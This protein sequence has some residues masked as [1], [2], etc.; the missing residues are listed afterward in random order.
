MANKK[1]HFLLLYELS[2]H[3]H[4]TR[5]NIN[6][7]WLQS[8]QQFTFR[9]SVI[10][11]EH[12]NHSP[13]HMCGLNFCSAL[14]FPKLSFIG[15]PLRFLLIPIQY[16]PDVSEGLIS[17]N[18]VTSIR[19]SDDRSS[20]QVTPSLPRGVVLSFFILKNIHLIVVKIPSYTSTLCST[21]YS[22]SGRC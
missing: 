20:D 8:N 15:S 14:F 4:Q 2:M 19:N 18:R 11:S 1:R 13:A 10:V 3:N 9:W 17:R 16:F 5:R 22:R 21:W 7:C 12:S 6:Q